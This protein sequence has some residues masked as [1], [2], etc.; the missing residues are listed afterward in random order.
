MSAQFFQAPDI[1]PRGAAV[2]DVTDEGH[3]QARD[4]AAAL[5]NRKDVEQPLRRMFMGP[6][7]S[8]DHRAIEVLGQQ[9]RGAGR[10]MSHDHHVD[11]HG[12]DVLGGVDK[13]LALREAARAPAR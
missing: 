7:A 9:F 12:L 6:V 11:S 10:A 5:A 1:R 8:I 4:L 3:G 13:R 2:S